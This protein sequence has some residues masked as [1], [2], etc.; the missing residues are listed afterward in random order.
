MLLLLLCGVEK[1]SIIAEYMISSRCMLS[2]MKNGNDALA[3]H[4]RTNKVCSRPGLDNPLG[5]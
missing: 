5:R 3:A 1:E 4:L 2:W